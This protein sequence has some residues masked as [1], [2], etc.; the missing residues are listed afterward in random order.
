[1]AIPRTVKQE[2]SKPYN[3]AM[4]NKKFGTKGKDIQKL[5]Y[6]P[7]DTRPLESHSVKLYSLALVNCVSSRLS[8]CRQVGFRPRRAD[9]PIRLWLH[10]EELGQECPFPLQLQQPIGHGPQRPD[11]APDSEPI[12]FHP[13]SVPHLI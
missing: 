4:G 3:R 9:D 1:M 6:L 2:T 13:L 11:P 12:P 10:G 7:C 8:R 5:R